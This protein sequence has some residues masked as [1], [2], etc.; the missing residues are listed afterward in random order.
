MILFSIQGDFKFPFKLFVCLFAERKQDQIRI[1]RNLILGQWSLFFF[2]DLIFIYHSTYNDM[3]RVMICTLCGPNGKEPTCNAGHAGS[4]P[5]L[6]RSP[7]E[8]NSS[9]PQYSCLENS[10]DRGAW[11][12]TI[13][14]VTNSHSRLNNTN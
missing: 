5:G 3:H 14:G 10:M 6:G 11:R 8:G 9:P 7:A 1:P 4:N 12:A 2:F 13:H